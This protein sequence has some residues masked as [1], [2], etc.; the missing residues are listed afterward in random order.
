MDTLITN[1]FIHFTDSLNIDD[2]CNGGL[3]KNTSTSDNMLILLGLMHGFIDF[4]KAFDSV[5]RP[6]RFYK[7]MHLGYKGKLVD[8][9]RNKTK[10]R[11]KVKH[12][13]SSLLKETHGVNQGGVRTPFLFKA[14]LKDLNGF[15]STQCGILS[16]DDKDTIIRHLLWAITNPVQYPVSGW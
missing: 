12:V 11:V 13:L 7:L 4:M 1:R 5:N 6:L 10:S 15:L 2:E 14:F 9:L 8:L 16:Q 3:K